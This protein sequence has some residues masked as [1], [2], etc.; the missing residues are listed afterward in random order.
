LTAAR[1]TLGR[2]RIPIALAVAGL[3]AAALV[4][5]CRGI[6][7]FL[8]D[9]DL[10]GDGVVSQADVDLAVSCLGQEFPLPTITYDYGGCPLRPPADTTG[11]AAADVDRDGVVTQQDVDAVA[12][13]LGER[14]CNGA[15]ELCDRR[16]DEVAYATTHNAMSARFDPYDYSIVVSNQCSGVPTQLQDGIRALMLDFHLYAPPGTDTPDLYLCHEDCDFGAQL[17]VDGLGEIRDFLA[18]HPAEVISLIIETDADTGDMEDAIR[19][20]FDASGLT[21]YTYVQT[22]GAPWATLG[23]MIASN[24]RLVVLTD[25]STPHA[26]CDADGRPCPW[27]QYLWASL[28]FETPYT[29]LRASD[30]TCH[31][32]RGQPGNDLFILNQFITR[33]TGAPSYARVANGDFLLD[34]RARDCWAYQGRIPNFVTVDFYEI[35]GVLRSVNLLNYLW[36][37]TGGIAP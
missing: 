9:P 11:C 4:A 7:T 30:F 8:I 32:N 13:H 3:L 10:D 24:Q 35:G 23:D 17:L 2:A 14:V 26:R 20:A 21:P 27:Y 36:G 29:F 37:Q 33:N 16:F 34:S 1:L 31:N 28:A 5:A 18:A 25:D 6:P 19:D 22:P 12:A 15:T